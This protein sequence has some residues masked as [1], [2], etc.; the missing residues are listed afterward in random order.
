[1]SHYYY[2][3]D[4]LLMLI[5]QGID[6]TDESQEQCVYFTK[7]ILRLSVYRQFC[8]VSPVCIHGAA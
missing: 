7:Q 3:N 6:M 4:G 8:A 1:M 5:G 2:V